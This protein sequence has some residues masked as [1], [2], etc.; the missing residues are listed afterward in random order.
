MPEMY[1]RRRGEVDTY[2]VDAAQDGE[3]EC[4]AQSRLVDVVLILADADRFGIDLDKLGERVD[5][6]AADGNG[7][8]HG[9]VFVGQ[10]LACDV[11]RGVDGRAVLADDEQLCEVGDA[12][13]AQES[14]G[15]ARCGAVAQGYGLY[16]VAVDEVH[17][18]VHGADGVAAR[19]GGVY[20]GVVEEVAALVEC[21]DLAAGTE[22]RIYGYHALGAQGRRHEELAQV[23]G[24]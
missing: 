23:A 17:E 22:A 4:V 1:P 13:R 21:H 7:A 20:D 9:D 24:E 14:L 11:G 16:V 10:L 5:E 3:V 6:A 8:A 18:H 12:R 19:L 15:L 2:G